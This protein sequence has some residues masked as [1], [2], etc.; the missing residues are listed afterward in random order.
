MFHS[1]DPF[2]RSISRSAAH[3]FNHPLSL[4]TGPI[5][6]EGEEDNPGIPVSPLPYY[7]FPFFPTRGNRS[8]AG[9]NSQLE[10]LFRLRQG[11]RSR[12]GSAEV[13]RRYHRRALWKSISLPSGHTRRAR[14]LTSD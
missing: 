6:N 8:I 4:A 13:L 9:R 5:M 1:D 7:A 14:G 11:A 2:D 10:I 12:D 3:V